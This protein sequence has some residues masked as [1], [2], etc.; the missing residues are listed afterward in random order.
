M[1][2][3]LEDSDLQ[4]CIYAG[5]GPEKVVR[6]MLIWF[7][8]SHFLHLC[9]ISTKFPKGAKVHCGFSFTAKGVGGKKLAKGSLTANCSNYISVHCVKYILEAGA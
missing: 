7:H 8:F 4:F 9:L 5:Q 1:S 3:K 6:H 2:S